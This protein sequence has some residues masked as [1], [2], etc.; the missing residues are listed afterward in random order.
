MARYNPCKW[1]TKHWSALATLVGPTVAV[2]ALLSQ[3]GANWKIEAARNIYSV[4]KYVTDA[5]DRL[6]KTQFARN[7]DGSAKVDV[8]SEVLRLDATIRAAGYLEPKHVLDHDDWARILF[9]ICSS[10][11]PK[12]Y[13]VEGLSME[14][15]AAAC[16]DPL[17]MDPKKCPESSQ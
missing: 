10:F 4:E 7:R 12:C 16:G 3:L 13:K 15:T 14:Y 6:T 11:R 5:F 2:V 17:P 1:K 9:P 8:Q